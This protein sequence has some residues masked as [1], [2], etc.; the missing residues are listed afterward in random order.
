MKVGKVIRDTQ[1][2][3]IKTHLKDT[4][5]GFGGFDYGWEELKNAVIKIVNV[6]KYKRNYWSSNFT[7]EFDVVVDMRYSEGYCYSNKYC[8]RFKK[9]SNGYYRSRIAKVLMNEI[10]YFG[11]DTQRD[12]IDIK[13]ITYKE[14][15]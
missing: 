13:K 2:N 11:S 10:K 8:E 3:A 1:I 14:I 4:T 12:E 6:R 7:F 9:R 15:V 5:I